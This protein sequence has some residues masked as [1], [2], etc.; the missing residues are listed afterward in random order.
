[1]I[2]WKKYAD[3]IF[4]IHYLPNNRLEKI[5]KTL[6]DIGIDINDN[7]FFSFMYD[8]EHKMFLN[9]YNAMRNRS[10]D[11][12]EKE[13]QWPHDYNQINDNHLFNLALM[14][15]NIL[16]IAQHFK[17]ERIIIFE[18]DIIFLKD[19][20]YII[21]A[22][23]F[24][25]TQDFDI[26]SC[27][28]SFQDCFHGISDYL[29]NIN[30]CEYLGNDMFLKTS[31]NLGVYNASFL[32]LTNK[33]I[34]KIIDFFETNNVLICLDALEGLRHK[35][36]LEFMFALKPLCIQEYMLDTVNHD[37]INKKDSNINRILD[38]YE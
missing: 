22:L 24:V 1:M 26:C 17:Y 4:C 2:D 21:K 32:I 14:N 36:N 8:I 35:L 5:S 16:K 27:E 3:Y 29:I 38:E 28:T 12:I 11:I 20:N 34:N 23:D 31:N 33:G 18:D 15:Y 37:N 7:K 9:E 10:W 25:N 6:T 19:H 30:G 13:C